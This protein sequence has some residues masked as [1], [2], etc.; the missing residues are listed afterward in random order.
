METKI[1]KLP[2]SRIRTLTTVTEDERLK[3]ENIAIAL[4]TERVE[5]KGFRIGKAPPDMVKSRVGT[6]KLTEETIRALLPKVM[7]EA[8]EK[9]GAKPILRPNANVVSTKPLVIAL[10]FVERPTVTLKKPDAISIEKKTYTETTDK[11]AETFIKKILTQD[12][13]ESPVDRQAKKGDLVTIAMSAKKKETQIDELTV[14]RYNLVI[15]SEDLL[16]QLEEH[17]IG[18]KK[19]EK[20]TVQVTFPKNHDIPGIR[21]EKI[22]IDINV[23]SVSEIQLPELTQ[24]YI[25]T[26]LGRDMSPEQFR[27]D[28]KKMLLDRKKSEEMKRR[29]EE[30]YEKVKAATQVDVAEELL[31]AEVQDMVQDLHRRLEEQ[32]LSMDDWLKATGKD[33]KSVVDEM[34]KI[35]SSRI[36]LRFGMQELAN[37]RKI[38]P[39]EKRI[40]EQISLIKEQAKND[41]HSTRAEDLVP[42]GTVYEQIKFD[43]KMQ[44]LVRIM[45]KDEEVKAK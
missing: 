17:V 11:E 43:L 30:L 27:S 26:R 32:K 6:E 31:D 24:E 2:Q 29:E 22:S 21:G 37:H 23:L 39:D 34:K 36:V 45:L 13:K 15:G 14:G 33:A 7:K 44:E 40:T 10:V 41:G 35:A 5:I 3:A 28:V 9:S 42:G 25:K 8:L 4:L 20:K 1:E 18:T 12:R 38:E 19:D 16:P